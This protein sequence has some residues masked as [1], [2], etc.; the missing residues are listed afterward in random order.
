MAKAKAQKIAYS[1]RREMRIRRDK[2]AAMMMQS[3][4]AQGAEGIGRTASIACEIADVLLATLDRTQPK[5]ATE[6]THV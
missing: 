5:A 3:L 6:G 4:L 1:Q 2:T